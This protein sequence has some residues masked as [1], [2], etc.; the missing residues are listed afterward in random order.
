MAKIFG[1][2]FD[3]ISPVWLQVLRQG[4]MNYTLQGT[5]DIDSAWMKNVRKAGN[6]KTKSEEKIIQ[7]FKDFII[8]FGFVAVLPRVV[9]EKFENTDFT[10][11][12]SQK[13]ERENVAKL[14]IESCRKNKFD[15][16]VLEIWQTLAKRIEDSF[17]YGLV[18]D[19]A[20]PM[21]TAG[22]DLILV[23]PPPRDNFHD[24]FTKENF[25]ELYPHVS[26]FSLMTYDFST[27][28]RPGANAPLY[29]VKHAIEN[30]CPK[31]NH[32]RSKILVGLNFYG[33]DY[34]P[35]GG[36]SI[37]GN[38]YLKYLT[39]F[40]DRLSHDDHDKEN[41]FEL[42][43]KETGRHIIFYPTLY[44]INERIQLAQEMGTGISIWELGQGLDYFYDLF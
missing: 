25:D 34:T 19:L 13:L 43:S 21:K 24:L 26:A 23:I 33:Y 40:K 1:P 38:E 28:E 35:Q 3:L 44:S 36:G 10:S 4:E 30:I 29:W 9:F 17:L 7:K 20:K 18:K 12:L 16:I 22:L 42:K 6:G 37:T 11:L 8:S 14:L 15:G 41:F 32:R 5:H 27:L 31:K 39:E 2:K